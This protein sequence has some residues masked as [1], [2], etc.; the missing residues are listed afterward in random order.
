VDIELAR[1]LEQVEI[2]I[3]LQYIEAKAKLKPE[4]QACWVKVAD[5]LLTYDGEDSPFTQGLGL[6]TF[7]AVNDETLKQIEAFFF[8]RDC[9]VNLEISPLCIEKVEKSNI[10][11]HPLL[12][13]GY[14]PIL[15][16]SIMYRP[17]QKD[18]KIKGNTEK[19]N[20]SIRKI[21]PN[22]VR[23]WLKISMTGYSID[24]DEMEEIL[25]DVTEVV[26]SRD[27]SH[28]FYAEIKQKPVA[29]GSLYIHKGIALLNGACT[30]PKYRKKG[31]Q[32][33]LLEA[34]L[35]YAVSQGC[36]LAMTREP[37]DSPVLENL[38]KQGFRIAYARM[39]WQKKKKHKVTN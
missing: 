30:L 32:L 23:D 4:S 9:D 28:C 19:A 1:R 18:L 24:D 27:D 26:S 31:I 35:N 7:E 38:E 12:S 34:R 20:L 33:A 21:L 37:P 16:T 8:D 17:I 5:A 39:K 22:E 15:Q 25:F 3:S 6:G 14:F 36:D 11:S 29:T 10:S 13:R 2:N